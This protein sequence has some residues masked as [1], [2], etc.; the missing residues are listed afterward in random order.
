MSEAVEI[1][2]IEDALAK[3]LTDKG[4]RVGW[5]DVQK[6]VNGIKLPA[7]YVAAESAKATRVTKKVSKETVTFG[8]YL[9][10]KNYRDQKSRREGL[11]PLVR[12]VI[13]IVMGQKLGLDIAPFR[14]IRWDETGE[15]GLQPLG[16]MAIRIEFQTDR[17]LAVED[18][19]DAARDLVLALEY[20]L[21]PGDDMADLQGTVN[22]GEE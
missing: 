7:C 13:A 11:L 5:V 3:R 15:E 1:S 21:K 8:A 17:D 19:A 16:M 14:Y 18:D 12:S 10:L 2:A 6:G 4:L 20:F 9:I 22:L